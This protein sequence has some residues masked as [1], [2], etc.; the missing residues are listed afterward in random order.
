MGVQP[1]CARHGGT[2][3]SRGTQ[4]DA[5]FQRTRR[6]P[7]SPNCGP[8]GRRAKILTVRRSRHVAV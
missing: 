6:G 3:A 4:S 5:Q 1:G 8:A 7:G 2:K